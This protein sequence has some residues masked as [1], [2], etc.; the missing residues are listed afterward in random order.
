MNEHNEMQYKTTLTVDIVYKNIGG[1]NM[2]LYRE[3]T[4]KELDDLK[5]LLDRNVEFGLIKSYE[6]VILNYTQYRYELVPVR[7]SKNTYVYE[8]VDKRWRRN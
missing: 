1:T 7:R 8:G 2:H 4:R 5:D 6:G 3:M